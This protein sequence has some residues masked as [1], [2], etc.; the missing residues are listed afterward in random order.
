[1]LSDCACI[2][3]QPKQVE[4]ISDVRLADSGSPV[5]SR[6]VGVRPGCLQRPYNV[7]QISDHCARAPSS[8]SY[9][10]FWPTGPCSRWRVSGPTHLPWELERNARHCHLPST[11]RG[12]KGASAVPEK[13]GELTDELV[14]GRPMQK[15][16]P[17]KSLSRN[18]P[19][20]RR[21]GELGNGVMRWG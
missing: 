10:W 12:V 19:F 3:L 20:S 9:R 7:Q 13:C 17:H 21:S 8:F 18:I 15:K 11:R 16:M 14:P 2:R 5:E 1:M 4:F 6:A